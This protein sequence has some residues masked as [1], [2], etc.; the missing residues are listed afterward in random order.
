MG[1]GTTTPTQRLSV[2][3]NAQFTGV[4]SGAYAYDLNLTSDGTLT[5]SASD[6]TLKKNIEILNS[7]DTLERIML[8]NPSTFDWKSNNAHD[9]GLIAQEVEIIFP[10]IVFTNPTDHLKGINYSRLPALLVSGMQEMWKTITALA[11]LVKT[12]R[13]ET[14]KL[15]IGSTCVT[16]TQLQQLL[17]SNHTPQAP[18]SPQSEPESEPT[19]EPETPDDDTTQDQNPA[20]DGGSADEDSSTPSDTNET[21]GSGSDGGNAD[22]T[23]TDPQPETPEIETPQQSSSDDTPT[24]S[25]EESTTGS[26]TPS[27]SST[28]TL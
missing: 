5:T 19:P 2:A 12:K 13:V 25:I 15:C 7:K 23:P 20:V 22:T 11:D 4:G 24:N 26:D 14:E 21:T 9:I 17:Q 10:E 16:E 28:E 18:Q 6:Q 3:G 1:I 27:T 8:L